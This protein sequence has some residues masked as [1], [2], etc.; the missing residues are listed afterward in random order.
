VDLE[1]GLREP[2]A[3]AD[4]VREREHVADRRLLAVEPR[5]GLEAAEPA[6]GHEVRAAHDED[7][8]VDEEVHRRLLG[9]EREEPEDDRAEDESEPAHRASGSGRR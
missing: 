2:R 7:G 1:P 8:E 4:R 3:V 5:T 6:P 9:R